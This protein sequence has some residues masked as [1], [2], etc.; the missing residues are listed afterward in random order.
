M[1]DNTDQI[2]HDTAK[3]FGTSAEYLRCRVNNVA[4]GAAAGTLIGFGF[5]G[6]GVP[7]GTLLGGAAG[8]WR[9]SKKCQKPDGWHASRDQSSQTRHAL[10]APSQDYLRNAMSKAATKQALSPGEVHAVSHA[11][12]SASPHIASMGHAQMVMPHLRSHLTKLSSTKA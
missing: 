2:F 3:F 12:Q 7:I 6:A 4:G 1:S 9:G 10:T 11:M 8:L 5:G